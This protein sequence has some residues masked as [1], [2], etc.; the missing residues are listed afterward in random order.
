[1]PELFSKRRAEL[2]KELM[3]KVKNSAPDA[4][5]AAA[6]LYMELKRAVAGKALSVSRRLTPVLDDLIQEVFLRMLDRSKL[7]DPKYNVN[8]WVMRITRN[9]CID[10]MRY[11]KVR[12]TEVL[13]DKP[14]AIVEASN[15]I[16]ADEQ[17]A[18][19]ELGLKKLPETQQLVLRKYYLEG[20][21]LE[22]IISST[23]FKKGTI[24]CA[25]SRGIKALRE[26]PNIGKLA[27]EVD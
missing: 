18:L 8:S 10:K 21:N 11:E 15:Q 26:N 7:Y 12:E 13:Q 1:M 25:M 17:R 14:S 27:P 19:I 16:E 9:I 23:K 2:Q 20:D 5:E 6:Q 4:Q 3:L 24:T 22:E